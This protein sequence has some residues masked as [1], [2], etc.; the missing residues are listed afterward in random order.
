MEATWQGAAS[1]FPAPSSAETSAKG[2][3]GAALCPVVLDPV[4]RDYGANSKQALGRGKK[5]GLPRD[6]SGPGAGRWRRQESPVKSTVFFSFHQMRLASCLKS[7]LSCFY[8]I[9]YFSPQNILPR[10]FFCHVFLPE[11]AHASSV[12]TSP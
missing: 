5:S 1:G 4:R 11:L 2:F 9:F 12:I 6:L 8:V 10:L 3:W 7:H